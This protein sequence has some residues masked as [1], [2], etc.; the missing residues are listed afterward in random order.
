[1][2]FVRKY[3]RLRFLIFQ[4][5]F[6]SKPLYATTAFNF[7]NFIFQVG[8]NDSVVKIEDILEN[9]KGKII[10]STIYD[11]NLEWH[12]KL[13][14]KSGRKGK[15]R[16]LIDTKVFFNYNRFNFIDPINRNILNNTFY[17]YAFGAGLKLL[18][19]Y[20]LFVDA[21]IARSEEFYYT[22]PSANTISF[23]N[24]FSYKSKLLLGYDFFSTNEHRLGL[25]LGTIFILP[26]K[27][28]NLYETG[29]DYGFESSLYC[30]LYRLNFKFSYEKILKNSSVFKQEESYYRFLLSYK[31]KL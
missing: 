17:N 18:L 12:Q 21:S 28:E 14:S 9:T 5:I 25:N 6:I 11:L 3:L 4:F 10:S 26:E 1:M 27:V 7:N 15:W 19:Y 23:K 22:T 2:C 31:F 16:E 24:I 8:V 29:L 13:F 20:K 30:S